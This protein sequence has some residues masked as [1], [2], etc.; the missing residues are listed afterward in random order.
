MKD[1]ALYGKVHSEFL[2]V[3]EDFK[4]LDKMVH[5]FGS[6]LT[7]MSDEEYAIRIKDLARVVHTLYDDSDWLL[8][9]LTEER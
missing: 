2:D 3:A 9:T 1:Y 6:E 5:T 4:L 8:T 7:M